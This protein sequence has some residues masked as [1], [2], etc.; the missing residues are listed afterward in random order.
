ML[1]GVDLVIWF[2]PARIS[3]A[4]ASTKATSLRGFP[5]HEAIPAFHA[6]LLEQIPGLTHKWDKKSHVRVST[7]LKGAARVRYL[8]A[9]YRLVCFDLHQQAVVNPPLLRRPESRELAQDAWLSIEDPTSE[10]IARVA[11]SLGDDNWFMSLE[12]DDDHFLQC[13]YGTR[14]GVDPGRYML[15]TRDDKHLQVEVDD[16]T[17]VIAAFESHLAGDDSWRDRFLWRPVST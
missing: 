9:K 15:E 5:P 7:T 4:E 8:A 6:E 10:H 12:G 14:A 16:V 11:R 3:H 13:G 2:E 1:C 17:V